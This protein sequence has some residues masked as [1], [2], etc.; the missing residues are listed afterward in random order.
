MGSG[1]ANEP[2]SSPTSTKKLGTMRRY[3]LVALYINRSRDASRERSRAC[4][5][6]WVATRAVAVAAAALLL[7]F[8]AA[9]T[10]SLGLASQFPYAVFVLAAG[11]LTLSTSDASVVSVDGLVA[12]LR[13]R[14]A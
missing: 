11:A 4:P 6:P 1:M 3:D 12:R 2:T 7:L 13:R 5:L 9:M 8:G 10:V 14:D